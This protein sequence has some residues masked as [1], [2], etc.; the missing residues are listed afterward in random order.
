MNGFLIRRRIRLEGGGGWTGRY[1]GE[2]W[3]LHL[4]C[5]ETLSCRII[6][7]NR[8][9]LSVFRHFQTFFF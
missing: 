2:E 3:G 1:M 6:S 5:M 9:E 4:H 8:I 7:G